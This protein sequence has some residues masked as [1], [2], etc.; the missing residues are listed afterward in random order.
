MM[1]LSQSNRVLCFGR[2][3]DV[4]I[5]YYDKDNKA[6]SI[7]TPKT[8]M[9]PDISVTLSVIPSNNIAAMTVTIRNMVIDFDISKAYY[10]RVS[11]GYETCGV[12]I[13]E[14]IIFRSYQATPNPDG[15]FVFEGV[16]TGDSTGYQNDL[17]VIEEDPFTLQCNDLGKISL[18]SFIEYIL[19]GQSDTISL[20]KKG[21]LPKYKFEII[22]EDSGLEQ[23]L[24]DATKCGIDINKNTKGFATPLSRAVY[25]KLI[26]T[27]YI[28]A[29]NIV[30]GKGNKINIAVVIDGNKFRIKTLS[31]DANVIP[32]TA[33]DIVGYNSASFN[34]AYLSLTMPYYPAIH[35]GSLLRCDAS[36]AT[37][38]GL[39]NETGNII[40]EKNN[41]WSLYRVN[42]FNVTF[43]TVRDNTMMID[44]FPI[45][46]AGKVTVSD[47]VKK[48]DTGLSYV[49]TVLNKE[50]NANNDYGDIIAGNITSDNNVSKAMKNSMIYARSFI[51]GGIP[52]KYNNITSDDLIRIIK[53]LYGNYKIHTIPSDNSLVQ[54]SKEYS[55]DILFPVVFEATWYKNKSGDTSYCS[56]EPYY[57]IGFSSGY[58]C[59]VSSDT[60][61]NGPWNQIVGMLQD[62]VSIYEDKPG[63]EGYVNIWKFMIENVKG[64]T[65]SSVEIDR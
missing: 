63:F 15:E 65:I 3:I 20:P 37:Q 54:Y 60:L 6:V 2:I 49:E 22:V 19:N 53:D 18:Y 61:Q 24:K 11:M 51:N 35:A 7:S 12:A 32:D 36:F 9:K 4:D 25:A 13:Y 5:Y 45:R 31:N 29:H 10:M 14:S 64:I 59:M 47:N 62:F 41:A 26:L 39:P 27:N 48:L 16:V 40:L 52:K 34:G 30:N 33:I 56:C 57:P 55:V 58:M 44:A 50:Y 21:K 1:D 23:T 43:S 17:G 38:V 42:K 8:G 28:E 46:E